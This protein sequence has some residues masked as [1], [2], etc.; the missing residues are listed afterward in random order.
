MISGSGGDGHLD[1]VVGLRHGVQARWFP[2]AI[3]TEIDARTALLP[4]LAIT[5]RESRSG[6]TAMTSISST[7]G[8]IAGDVSS[9]ATWSRRERPVTACSSNACKSAA[10]AKFFGRIGPRLQMEI[11]E[12]DST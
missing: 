11:D 10:H 5:R 1:D 2:A 12:L 7:S 3:E 4:A 6:R 8:H 9:V